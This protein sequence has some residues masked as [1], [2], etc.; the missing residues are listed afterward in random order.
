[1]K[2][3]RAAIGSFISNYF[4]LILLAIILGTFVF[5]SP[6]IKMAITPKD[7]SNEGIYLDNYKILFHKGIERIVKGVNNNDKIENEVLSVYSYDLSKSDI[8]FSLDEFEFKVYFIFENNELNVL[9]NS[10]SCNIDNIL[11]KNHN[12][13]YSMYSPTCENFNT[14][15]IDSTLYKGIVYLKE[16]NFSEQISYFEENKDI[17][18]GV[19]YEK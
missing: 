19:S 10:V 9:L 6:F 14:I 11:V 4:S 1:M 3:K 15:I 7:G 8:L 2:S 12:S 17:Y 13:L 16:H 5:T 18:V